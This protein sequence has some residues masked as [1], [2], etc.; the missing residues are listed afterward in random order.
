MESARPDPPGT[1]K[2]GLVPLDVLSQLGRGAADDGVS[3]TTAQVALTAPPPNVVVTSAIPGPEGL[4]PDDAGAAVAAE[5]RID[6]LRRLRRAGA[7]GSAGE[8]TVIELEDD[9]TERLVVLGLG[10]GSPA[11]ARQAGAAMATHIR[12]VERVLCSATASLSRESLRALCEGLLL[13]SYRF[14]RKSGNKSD[15]SAPFVQLA[16][17]SVAR[18]QPVLDLAV[19]TARSVVLAR[20]LAN[21]PGNDKSPRWIAQ[22]AA[23]LAAEAGQKLTVLDGARLQRDGFGGILAVGSGSTNPPCLIMMEQRGDTSAPHVVLI[24]KGVTFDSGGLSIKPADA[25]KNMKTDMAG[26]AAVLG[27]MRALPALGVST[28]VTALL[29]CAENMPGAAAMRPGDVVTHFGGSTSEITN[30]DAEGRLLLADALAFARA[31]LRPDVVIDV[32]TLTG[33]ASVALGRG[34]AALFSNSEGL[35]ESLER[36]GEAAGEPMWL[37][38]LADEYRP[39]L[40]SAVADFRNTTVAGGPGAIQAALFLR[41]FVGDERWAHLDIAGPARCEKS[42]REISRGATG[43]GV[44]ALLRWLEQGSALW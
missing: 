27:V 26:A 6:L 31:R 23:D 16:V 14:S 18:S 15:A 17:A 1:P 9:T 8:A 40:D 42:H 44:R 41:Q 12:D 22:R 24:G 35:A 39:S 11:A 7:S 36:A 28:R 33:A 10:D 2:L 3:R 5:H 13:A 4:V 43:Y 25:M 37:M 38:P 19:A 30:T 21:T 20:D 32:A 29:P 34:H